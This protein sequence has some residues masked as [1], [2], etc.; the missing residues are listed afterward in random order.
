[1]IA[2]TLDALEAEAHQHIQRAALSWLDAASTILAIQESGLWQARG[3]PTW[4]EYVQVTFGLS[5]SRIRQYRMAL[6]LAHELLAEGIPSKESVLRTAITLADN[7]G[8]DPVQVVRVAE[9][10]AQIKGKHATKSYIQSAVDTLLEARASNA[11][12]L[13]DDLTVMPPTM[14]GV[15]L[16][17]REQVAERYKQASGGGIT[18]T[19][20]VTQLGEWVFTPD[21]PEAIEAGRATLFAR[22]KALA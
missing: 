2:I 4:G 21:A 18:G 13:H 17:T 20:Q 12:T 19:V 6:P 16:A 3:I 1:M 8:L 15:V 9:Q 22:R 5:A 11:V 7:A 10:A 14:Q